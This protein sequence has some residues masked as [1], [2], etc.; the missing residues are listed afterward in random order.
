V[1]STGTDTAGALAVLLEPGADELEQPAM[2]P[3]AMARDEVRARRRVIRVVRMLMVVLRKATKMKACSAL[4]D[5]YTLGR[6]TGQEEI[7][8]GGV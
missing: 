8:G 1:I 3:A 7:L 5:G 2:R 6:I 4:I